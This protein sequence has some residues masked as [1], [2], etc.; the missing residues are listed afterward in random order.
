MVYLIYGTENFLLEKEL[1][2]ILKKEKIEEIA[3]SHYDYTIDSLK[4]ILEDAQTVPFF[5]EKKAIIVDNATFFNRGKGEEGEY[6]LLLDYFDHP[7]EFTHLLFLNHNATIDTTKKISKKL[8]SIGVIKE[9]TTSSPMS[10][11]EEMLEGYEISKS[12]I[13][14]LQE[15]VGEDLSL[16]QEETNKLKL[17]KYEEK[18]ITEE[19]V[20]NLTTVTLD[21]DI[22]RFIDY[23]IQKEKAKAFTMYE[24]M[25]KE[26]EEP[27]KMIALL[28]SKFRLMYQAC[29]LTRLGYSQADISST[30]GVHI[31]PVKLAIQ[32]GLKYD[33]RVLL[34]Y[35][36]RLSELDISIKTGKIEPVLGLELLLLSV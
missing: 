34:S 22:F 29:E 10:E 25:I 33:S 20:K 9:L 6:L 14:L 26:G 35:M 8:K 23:I 15:R 4:T 27:I 5:A 1:Q 7:N 2:K 24:E 11:V 12:T 19:D 3:I 16:L 17:Y 30:L 32:A 31:Y 28:A 18:K 21:T 36:K 13:R